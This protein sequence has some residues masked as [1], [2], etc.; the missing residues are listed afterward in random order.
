M[1]DSDI[2]QKL[3]MVCHQMERDGLTPSVGLLRNKAPFKVSVT[4]AIEAVK[5]FNASRKRPVVNTDTT[6]SPNNLAL[7]EK[8]I[9]QLEA[10][11]QILE[12]RLAD[13]Q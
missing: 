11:V 10:A 13:K 5:S 12:Q 9:T 8:R 3:V 7:L 2:I 6:E 4:Q 1:S